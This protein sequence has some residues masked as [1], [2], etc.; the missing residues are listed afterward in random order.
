MAPTYAA[1]D[2]IDEI[3]LNFSLLG[4]I[5]WGNQYQNYAKRIQQFKLWA[6]NHHGVR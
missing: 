3:L 2:N 6:T 4:D 1:V 5:N